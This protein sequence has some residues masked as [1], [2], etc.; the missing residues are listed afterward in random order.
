MFNRILK[1]EIRHVPA[2]KHLLSKT[3]LF[4][5]TNDEHVATTYQIMCKQKSMKLLLSFSLQSLSSTRSSY[6]SVFA[7]YVTFHR[8]S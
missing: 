5:M 3:Y 6:L 8:K 1:T 2:L 7:L 4:H